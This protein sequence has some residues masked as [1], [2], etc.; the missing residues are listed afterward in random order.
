M[1]TKSSACACA[2]DILST[3]ERNMIK[4]PPNIY[5]RHVVK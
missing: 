5:N 1:Y 2:P 3:Q 4:S